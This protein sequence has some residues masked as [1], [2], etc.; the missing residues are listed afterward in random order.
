MK[1][2]PFKF[3]LP[4]LP[5]IIIRAHDV[6]SAQAQPKKPLPDLLAQALQAY[7]TG[8]FDAA[9]ESYQT[10]LQQDPKS[11]EAYAGL[12]RTYLK[13][14]KSEGSFDTASTGVAEG[15]D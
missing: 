10:A 15:P 2:L 3:F 7:R 9:I 13:Q 14:D 5:A 6:P 8:K 11:G 1:H 12:A 4:L